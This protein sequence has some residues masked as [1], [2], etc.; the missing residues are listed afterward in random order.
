MRPSAKSLVCGQPWSAAASRR[1]S[2]LVNG[3]AL[4]VKV[5]SVMHSVLHVDAYRLS[6]VQDAVSVRDILIK[7]G[8]AEPMEEPY[9]SKVCTLS[10][11]WEHVCVHGCEV[12]GAG[13]VVALFPLSRH[14]GMNSRVVFGVCVLTA[15][16]FKN[17]C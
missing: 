1:F 6:G 13:V 8:Y 10:L 14:G 4:L 2:S 5:F 12:G 15:I 7:E 16:P 9:E 11:S 17:V 3:C